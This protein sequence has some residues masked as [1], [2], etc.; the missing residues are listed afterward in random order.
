MEQALI[1]KIITTMAA[2]GKVEH[3]MHDKF[4]GLYREGIIFAKIN[5]GEYTFLIMVH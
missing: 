1:S 5:A 2:I 3:R 4:V